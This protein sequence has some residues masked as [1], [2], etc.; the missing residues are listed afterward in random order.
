MV[1]N[2]PAG[3]TKPETRVQKPKRS[4][5]ELITRRETTQSE[6][7]SHLSVD[8]AETEGILA[9]KLE[10]KPL[11]NLWKEKAEFLPAT[12]SFLERCG[13]NP[14][15]VDPRPLG[16]GFTHIV[17]SY[18]PEGEPARVVKIPRGVSSGFMSG[19][20]VEDQDNIAMVRK[21]FGDYS[22]PTEVRM[23]QT[24][25]K[26]LYVQDIVGGKPVT[27]LTESQSIR[28][29]IAD[30]AR[31]NREMMR[32][33]QVSMDFLG[34]PG[35]LTLV[36]HQFWSIISRKSHFELSNIFEDEWGKLKLIDSGLI[37]FKDVPFKQ[38]MISHLGF[39]V[40]RI[41]MRLY[42]GVDIKP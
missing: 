37:R 23:D 31:L 32:Q 12:V 30:L 34:V 26:Y 36:R 1:E 24:T 22:V 42:F 9:R 38:R 18:H 28:T 16:Q 20:F 10:K 5:K 39:F 15:H 33:K 27:S 7:A 29:Q 21:F 4:K 6:R 40:N 3:L 17:F 19:S 14:D 25:G 2:A 8:L 41:I 13:I 11:P 35:F